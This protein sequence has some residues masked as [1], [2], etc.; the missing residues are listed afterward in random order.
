MHVGLVSFL[1]YSVCLN[2]VTHK[3]NV[4][5]VKDAGELLGNSQ[6]TAGV[7]PI[8]PGLKSMSLISGKIASLVFS[9]E[10]SGN[11]PSFPLFVLVV[12]QD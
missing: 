6:R 7:H 1:R 10:N 2:S 4:L 9:D 3:T 5:G 8:F 12:G 11:V